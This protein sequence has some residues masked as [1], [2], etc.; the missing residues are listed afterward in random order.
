MTEEQVWKSIHPDDIWAMDKLI[1]SRKMG[2]ICGPVGTSV[3]AP[4]YYIVR[5]C[6]NALGLGLGTQK[7]YIEDNTDHLPTGH[8]W[9][10]IFEGEHYS[11]DY[12]LSI[13]RLCVQGIKTTDTFVKWD[14]WRRIQHSIPLPKILLD[15]V[16]TSRYP[17]VNCEYIVDKLVEIHF[18]PNM[19]FIGGIN[20]FIPVW[21]GDDTT[22][23][24]GYTYRDYP[25]I[26]GRIG[27]FVK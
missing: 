6:V 17:W 8:F 27:A 18:R 3:P 11:V 19:D 9:C 12:N 26:H 16:A 22:P 13:Q 20:H 2:Y 7:I 10:E 25:D 24:D 15:I 14:E 21:E 1:V 4:D 5:P 23:P